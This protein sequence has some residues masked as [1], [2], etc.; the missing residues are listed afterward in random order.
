MRMPTWKDLVDSGCID[1]AESA[2]VI[3]ADYISPRT[4]QW[5]KTIQGYR[6]F[7]AADYAEP[8]ALLLQGRFDRKSAARHA[9][10]R[11]VTQDARDLWLYREAKAAAAD[12][13]AAVL[14]A[15]EDVQPGAADVIL[16]ELASVSVPETATA[17][18]TPG[19]ASD[20][21]AASQT[22]AQGQETPYS[23]YEAATAAKRAAEAARTA[24]N[25]LTRRSLIAA[26][27]AAL[28]SLALGRQ[29]DA[30]KGR[31]GKR[32]DGTERRALTPKI[33][34]R[35]ER[36]AAK[37]LETMPDRQG[38]CGWL[39][40]A[41]TPHAEDDCSGVAVCLTPQGQ[42]SAWSYSPDD[43]MQPWQGCYRSGADARQPLRHIADFDTCFPGIRADFL[44]EHN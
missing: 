37:A 5:C 14:N 8:D 6:V 10:A 22:P 30:G 25:V 20:S 28:A 29:A 41:Y 12:S 27:L 3:V 15:A 1:A 36:K 2:Y 17:P 7:M 40:D 35:M 24:G 34:R 9:V 19:K 13:T 31:Q 4:G 42:F 26:G 38:V 39:S 11:Q 44:N 32:R 18:E 16:A 23:H 21:L 33:A 43:G